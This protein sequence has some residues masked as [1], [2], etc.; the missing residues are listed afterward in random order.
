M[1]SVAAQFND[2]LSRR[3]FAWLARLNVISG[4]QEKNY[5]GF[6]VSRV[7]HHEGKSAVMSSWPGAIRALPMCSVH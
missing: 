1:L 6:I 5:E 3:V 4:L 2:P 7:M